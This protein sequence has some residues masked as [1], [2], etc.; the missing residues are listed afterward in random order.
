MKKIL[1]LIGALLLFQ[2]ISFAGDNISFVYINGSNNNDEKMKSWFE[3]GVT[4]LHPVMKKS[5]ENNEDAS[6]LFLDNGK[7]AINSDAKIFFWGD[8]SRNDLDFVEQQLDLSKAFSPTIA[9][10][11]RSLI[12]GFL[13]D[14]IWVQKSHHMHPILDDLHN[15]VM[16]EYSEGN[17]VVLFG[18]SAGS[19]IT[20]EYLFNKLPYLNAEDLF[21]VAGADEAV[22]KFVAENPRKNTCISAL[23]KAGLGAVTSDGK[24]R[25]N[26]N[27]EISK[28]RYLELDKYTEQACIPDG[29]LKGIVNFASPL[30]LFYSDLADPDY[31]LTYYNRFMLKYILEHNL[32]MLTVNF[33]EDPM[34]FPT[35]RNLTAKEFAEKAKIDIINPKG[36]I[37]DN[38]KVWSKRTFL[39]AHTSY[40]SARKTFSKAVAQSFVDGYN[41]TLKAVEK[42]ENVKE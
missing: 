30:V 16:K 34:G 24:L 20:Y 21:E 29:A 23:S 19:F 42:D 37:Y 10:G 38:S 41:F 39:L 5:F 1:L 2:N 8:K 12:A 4:K 35:T 13:H 32:F 36:F 7:Y 14:A 18:Y 15:T 25:F 40:W 17:Q 9:Y 31:E 28:G 11:V 3:N 33:K 26:N 22:R 6:A 27:R